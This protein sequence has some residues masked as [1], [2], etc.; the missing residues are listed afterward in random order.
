MMALLTTGLIG[1]ARGARKT[2]AQG[3]SNSFM[4]MVE[5]LSMKRTTAVLSISALA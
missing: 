3:I 1:Q 4:P 2:I 5:L